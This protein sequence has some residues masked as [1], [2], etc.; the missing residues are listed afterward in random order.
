[1]EGRWL[2]A[3]VGAVGLG[4]LF[5]LLV[6]GIV[7]R[8]LLEVLERGFDLG[9]LVVVGH[10]GDHD[11][12]AG[13]AVFERGAVGRDAGVREEIDDRVHGRVAVGPRPAV[14]EEV[15]HEDQGVAGDVPEVV[16]G[17]GFDTK[18]VGFVDETTDD[19]AELLWA[20]DHW[21]SPWGGG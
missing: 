16:I 4:V 15:G 6:V 20:G 7:A 5:L 10:V 3:A 12:E 19:Q 17:G 9:D 18:A 11:G 14:D 2:V 1:M 8:V 13:L 21:D